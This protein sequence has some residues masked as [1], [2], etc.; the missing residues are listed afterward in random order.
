MRSDDEDYDH[1]IVRDGAARTLSITGES[2]ASDH[3][4]PRARRAGTVHQSPAG[5]GGYTAEYGNC[6]PLKTL[7]RS[8]DSSD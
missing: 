8:V 3:W 2:W 4:P 1:D 5:T 7:E 6:T